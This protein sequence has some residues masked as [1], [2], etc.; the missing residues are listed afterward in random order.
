MEACAGLKAPGAEFWVSSM[1][2]LFMVQQLRPQQLDYLV[3]QDN[4]RPLFV[5]EECSESDCV[6][7]KAGSYPRFCRY[8][9]G[10]A[11][12]LCLRSADR[13]RCQQRTRLGRVVVLAN[14][15]RVRPRDFCDFE[16]RC[17]NIIIHW[18]L[19]FLT[20]RSVVLN[21]VSLFMINLSSRSA[22]VQDF[23]VT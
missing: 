10:S 15:R 2:K 20:L 12:W 18:I 3:G 14:Y 17:N 11:F 7:D 21:M 23:T 16:T 5:S 9:G 8:F 13:L 19:A 4:E 22:N 6:R 1:S